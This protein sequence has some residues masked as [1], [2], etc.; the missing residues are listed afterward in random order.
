MVLNVDHRVGQ[1][2][3]RRVSYRR[4]Q[5]IENNEGS[6]SNSG[7][8]YCLDHSHGEGGLLPSR[9][10]STPTGIFSGN[11]DSNSGNSGHGFAP[12]DKD[13]DDSTTNHLRGSLSLT[14]TDPS[15]VFHEAWL[16]VRYDYAMC[17]V[18]RPI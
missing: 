17:V 4:L 8:N 13:A 11:D 10:A 1:P 7:D 6:D 9:V 12:H 15:Y 18:R 14:A 2:I 3:Q 16:A 5:E